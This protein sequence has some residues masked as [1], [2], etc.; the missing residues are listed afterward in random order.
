MYMRS[1]VLQ[2][3][4]VLFI[5]T[6]SRWTKLSGWGSANFHPSW[7]LGV[8]GA[9]TTVLSFLESSSGPCACKAST[10]LT[11]LSLLFHLNEAV[12]VRALSLTPQELCLVLLPRSCFEEL[13]MML[14]QGFELDVCGCE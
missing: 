12:C 8:T 9:C 13:S 11:E 1:E 3:A 14:G 2:E 4:S 5:E 10:F 6:L 7:H